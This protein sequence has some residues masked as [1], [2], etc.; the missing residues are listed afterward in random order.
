MKQFP[1]LVRDDVSAPRLLGQQA[2]LELLDLRLI[3][4]E[5]RPQSEQ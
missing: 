3:P 4:L 5:R 1:V 2:L